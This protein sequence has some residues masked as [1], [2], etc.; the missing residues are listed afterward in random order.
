MIY[1][2]FGGRKRYERFCVGRKEKGNQFKVSEYVI[3]LAIIISLG[4]EV[5]FTT[6]GYCNPYVTTVTGMFE[7]GKL[8]LE[9]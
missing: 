2:C 6:T 5:M 4:A 8:G 1:V 3:Y 7:R 9:R